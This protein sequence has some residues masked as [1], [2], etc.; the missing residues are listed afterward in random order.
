MRSVC[1][2][3]R[4]GHQTTVHWPKLWYPPELLQGL[5]AQL[6][7][8][9]AVEMPAK[10]TAAVCHAH[11]PSGCMSTVQLSAGYALSHPA[12]ALPWLMIPPSMSLQASTCVCT[13]VSAIAIILSTA[14]PA[15]C[16]GWR[17]PEPDLLRGLWLPF[18]VLTLP[19]CSSHVLPLRVCPLPSLAWPAPFWRPW[20]EVSAAKNCSTLNS[21]C[22]QSLQPEQHAW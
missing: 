14:T 7:L 11:I 2:C 19:H 8:A 16:Q 17:D 4:R 9:A 1:D 6:S 3:L 13:I 18:P 22:L 15:N 21:L 5:S 10:V 12:G 20:S